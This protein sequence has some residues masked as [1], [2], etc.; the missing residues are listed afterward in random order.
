[1][2]FWDSSG[3]SWTICKQSAPHSRQITTP[4]PHHSVVYR[5]DA[6]PD[7]QPTASKDW[8]QRTKC[9]V[10]VV[11]VI[12]MLQCTYHAAAYAYWSWQSCHCICI[13]ELATYYCICI[14]ELAIMPLHMHIGAGNHAAAYAYWSWQSCHCIC[15]LELAS[16]EVVSESTVS[17]T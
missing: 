12:S 3:I 13:L 10:P 15:I 9:S 17:P 1:M 6:L 8:R 2:G 14:L 11:N 5:P 7:A 4:T 16:A